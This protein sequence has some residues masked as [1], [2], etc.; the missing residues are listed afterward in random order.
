MAA[1]FCASNGR[2]ERRGEECAVIS[3]Q[4]QHQVLFCLT[5]ISSCVLSQFLMIF[6]RFSLDVLDYARANGVEII[7]FPS[8]STHILQPADLCVFGPMKHYASI[9]R[10]AFAQR[11]VVSRSNIVQ[12]LREAVLAAASPPIIKNG[13]LEAGLVPFNPNVVLERKQQRVSD[14]ADRDGKEAKESDHTRHAARKKA[15]RDQR[16]SDDG[17]FSLTLVDGAEVKVPHNF[18]SFRH[19][20]STT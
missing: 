3:R 17:E 14:D 10:A 18:Q 5:E 2:S 13:W 9:A 6:V 12:V 1:A 19:R 8:N 20:V 16:E 15:K 4:P 7:G 11:G